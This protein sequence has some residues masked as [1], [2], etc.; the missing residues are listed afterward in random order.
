MS[1]TAKSSLPWMIPL[2]V[3]FVAVGALLVPIFECD[4]CSEL[5]MHAKFQPHELD[6]PCC[7]HKIRN[8][9]AHRWFTNHGVQHQIE[10]EYRY[11]VKYIEE[12]ERP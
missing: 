5:R 4:V 8:S 6:Y 9:L 1:A 2:V 7:G 11:R 12:R 10:L 3:A